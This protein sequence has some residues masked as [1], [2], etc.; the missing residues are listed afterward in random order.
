MQPFQSQPAPSPSHFRWIVV[1][2]LCAVA[3]VLYIDR[4][5]IMIAAPHLEKE[6]DLSSQM[7]GNVLSAFLFGYALGLVP[8]GWMADRFGPHRVLTLAGLSWGVLTVLMGCVPKQ[9]SLHALDSGVVLILAR[10]FLG[11]CEACAYPTFNRALANWMRRSERAFSSGLIHCGSGLGGAFTPVFIAVI[12]QQLGWRESFWLSGAIT[13]GVAVLWWKLTT[14]HPA[15]HAR[16]NAGELQ[17]IASEREELQP[18]P[19]DRQW[20]RSLARSQNAY[21]LCASEFLYGLSG[22]VYLTWF[23]IYFVKVR[24]AGDLYS[25]I[26]SSF[27]YLAMA[28]GAPIGGMLCDLCVKR[29]GSPWG[30]RTVPLVS[31]ALSGILGMI[32][33]VIA[34]NTLSAVVFSVAAGLQFV[35]ASAFWA[36]VIDITRC[37]T[38]VLGGFMNGSGNLGSAIG[39]IAFP[40]LVERLGWD[41]ALQVSAS[42]AIAS[43]LIWMFIDSSRQ[44]DIVQPPAEALVGGS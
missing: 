22:F 19:A 25:A 24:G 20:Y 34:N 21:M 11:I 28:V 31:I 29:W 13:L 37:G 12:V 32:A 10:F 7:M 16:V 44:I 27:T 14:D 6:F 23:Y 17:A 38:G 26:L 8:G 18:A 35:A 36:T 15:Q 3:F 9:V 1:A 33:P 4:I 39:T 41:L 43:G 42:A 40:W 2:L 5:N 30:R